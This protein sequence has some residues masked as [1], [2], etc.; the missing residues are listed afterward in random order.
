MLEGDFIHFPV[1]KTS[2]AK[3]IF[4]QKGTPIFATSIDIFKKSLNATKENKM[5]A[6]RWTSFEFYDEIPDKDIVRIDPCPHCFAE[7]T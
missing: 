3:D 2:Y 4:L 7:N 6:L 1:P 5:M